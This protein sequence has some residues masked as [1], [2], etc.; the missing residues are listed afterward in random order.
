MHE[1]SP[2]F[3]NI[4]KQALEYELGDKDFFPSC[5]MF[6]Y[7]W[8]LYGRKK[9]SGFVVGGRKEICGLLPRRVLWPLLRERRRHRVRLVE[10]LGAVNDL[11]S[12]SGQKVVSAF[13][14]SCLCRVVKVL[15]G[16]NRG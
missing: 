13:R 15:W 4:A 2:Q 3:D 5:S 9:R 14:K 12:W 6:V 7:R 11:D 10:I 1:I 16:L 8:G